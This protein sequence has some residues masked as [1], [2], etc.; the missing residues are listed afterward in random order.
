MLLSH[1]LFYTMFYCC[2]C[3]ACTHVYLPRAEHTAY[4]LT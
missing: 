4:L 1:N 2:N 3:T